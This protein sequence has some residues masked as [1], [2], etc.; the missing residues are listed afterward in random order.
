MKTIGTDIKNL[1]NASLQA[2]NGNKDVEALIDSMSLAPVLQ[3][4]SEWDWRNSS[5]LGLHYIAG[6]K[7]E[8]IYQ[9]EI[10]T[11]KTVARVRLL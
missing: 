2:I 7:F 10:E 1:V 4:R 3:T 8:V 11:M 5:S 6:D 9:V